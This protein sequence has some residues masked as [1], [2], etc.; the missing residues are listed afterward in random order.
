MTTES[1]GKQE[2][3]ELFAAMDNVLYNSVKLWL[4]IVRK[5]KSV[6][7]RREATSQFVKALYT[8]EEKIGKDT[9]EECFPEVYKEL[10]T[11]LRRF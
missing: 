4:I 1:D 3:M 6:R 11:I 8:L 10:H 9:F 5:L 2:E 7:A